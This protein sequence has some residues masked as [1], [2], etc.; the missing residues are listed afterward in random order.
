MSGP[1]RLP[2]WLG[3][4]L[5]VPIVLAL[6]MVLNQPRTERLNAAREALAEAGYPDARLIPAQTPSQ[7][8]RCEVGQIKRHGYAFAWRN[9]EHN[10]LYCLRQDG[11]PNRIIVD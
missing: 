5:L 1:R 3:L 6:V 7:L 9:A 2:R 10:G 8:S 4:L 11:R